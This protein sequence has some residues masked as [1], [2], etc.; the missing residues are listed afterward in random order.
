MLN[1]TKL[2]AIQ[3]LQAICE[4]TDKIQ[5]K[6]NWHS[7]RNREEKL[8]F[9]HY[10]DN[11][12]VGF[13][14]LYPFVSTVEVCGMVHP[15]HR[16]KQIFTRL[17]EEAKKIF[18]KE[19]YERILLNSPAGSKPGKDF[20]EKLGATYAFSESQMTWKPEELTV[21]NDIKLRPTT[22]EDFEIRVRLFVEGFGL[23]EEDARSLE[24]E[25]AYIENVDQL[26]IVTEDGPIGYIQ[27][28]RENQEAWISG[29]SILPE[30]QGKGI[31]RRVLQR[32]VKENAENGYSVHLEVETKNDHALK[33]YE[34][35]GFYVVHAQDYYSYKKEM[36]N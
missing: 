18:Q 10:E 32:V 27:V 5:L 9:F 22:N 21:D 29:F 35:T 2:D 6:L 1:K 26:M 15:S 33:L 7:L 28:K 17:F 3:E 16:R 11:V 12:L 30:H 13:L 20:L 31:G 4:E 23:P 24:K 36:A 34:S 8:D 19:K 25:V 14:G